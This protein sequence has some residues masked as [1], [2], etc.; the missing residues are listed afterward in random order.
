[1]YYKDRVEA[2]RKLATELEAYRSK[3]AIVVAL[4]ESSVVVARE[5]AKSLHA[6]LVLYMIRDINLPGE[7][8]AVAAISSTGAFRYND[9]LSPGEVTDIS[10]EFRNFIEQEKFGKLHEMNILLSGAGEIDKNRL[11]HHYVILVA[12]A[13]SDG[14]SL[15]MVYEYLKTVS[16]KK[17]VVAVPVVGIDAIDR[18]HRVAD[19]LHVGG[20]TDNFLSIDHYYDK[21]DKPDF[22]EVMSIISELS[23]EW[24]TPREAAHAREHHL[25]RNRRSRVLYRPRT[26]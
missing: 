4:S 2:G 21:N 8:T 11:R 17:I 12:D 16:T 10:S 25:G 3:K 9:T 7:T 24:Q 23:L 5:I 26:V 20:V 19:E 14:F 13:L 6:S 1:M 15:S 18:M 22:D